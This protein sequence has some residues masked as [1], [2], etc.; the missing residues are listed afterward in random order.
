MRRIL[1]TATAVF[2]LAQ[3]AH[4]SIIPVLDSV[5]PDGAN[6]KFNY[7][8][9]LAPDQGVTN[10]S[11]LVIVDF[12]GYVNG[13]IHASLPNVTTSISNTLPAGLLLDPNFTDDASIPDLVFTY[14][15]PDFQTSGGPFPS[16]IHFAGLSADSIFGDTH[17]G[18]FSAVAVRNTGEPQST[19]T[20]NVGQVLVPD[21]PTGMPEPASWALMI[22]GFL[23]LGTTLRM[24]RTSAAVPG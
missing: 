8:G 10:G 5:T 18:T 14:T 16:I 15:G 20:Y 23:G 24:R 1:L 9:Q 4:A 11:Q 19:P 6:F 21:A 17:A 12:A 7:D 2:A 13:S 22:L 3:T